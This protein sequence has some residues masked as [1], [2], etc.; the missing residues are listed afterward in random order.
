[1]DGL[2]LRRLCDAEDHSSEKIPVDRGKQ[3]NTDFRGERVLYQT[4]NVIIYYHGKAS[5]AF[6]NP[7]IM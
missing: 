7:G 1:M 3:Q 5:I 4:Y 2:L 6:H